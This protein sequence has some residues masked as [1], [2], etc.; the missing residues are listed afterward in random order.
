M[1]FM[2]LLGSC[3]S[4]KASNANTP[5]IS[6]NW[7]G[8]YSGVTPAADGPGI[9][10]QITLNVDKTFI[11]QYKYIDRNDSPFIHEGNFTWNKTGEIIVLDIENIP[12]YYKV[13]ENRLIQLDMQGKPIT[14]ELADLYI[15]E[16]AP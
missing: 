15:L 11:L 16:K 10:V 8:V 14:G 6:L 9:D 12:P 1:L 2:A 3:A 4:N 13:G 5:E 7:A